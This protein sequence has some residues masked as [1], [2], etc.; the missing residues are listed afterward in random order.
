VLELR[1]AQGS[2]AT[3]RLDVAKSWWAR[4]R[5]L[6]GRA[7]LPDGEGLYLPGTNSI[8]MLFMR[9][10]IDCVFVGAARDDGSREVVGVRQRLSPWTGV[11]WWVRGAKAAVELPAGSVDRSGIN[12]GDKVWLT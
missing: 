10:P 9:F 1:T 12:V 7:T 8:H 3:Y 4:A 6:M 2:G 5:G 11:V